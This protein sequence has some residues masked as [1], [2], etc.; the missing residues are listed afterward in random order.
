MFRRILGYK[1]WYSAN[2]HKR[3]TNGL[4][5]LNQYNI[6][7]A[8]EIMNSH[9][10][11]RAMFVRDPKARILSAHRDKVIQNHLY[12]EQ[13]TRCCPSGECPEIVKTFAGFLRMLQQCHNECCNDVHWQPQSRRV[14]RK[15]L[16]KID[17]IGHLKTAHED[18]KLLLQHIGAWEEFGESG[19]GEYRNESFMQSLSTS[20]RR[21]VT[22]SREHLA[23]YFTPELERIVEDMYASDYE[24]FNL[25]VLNVSQV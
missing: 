25:P 12:I 4:R 6:T 20:G 7:R 8:T 19:W 21:H 13:K 11:T 14:E 17:F 9:E 1:D 16:E 10:Y 2:P 3:K 24:V 18:A 23:E 5:F 15:F 22:S